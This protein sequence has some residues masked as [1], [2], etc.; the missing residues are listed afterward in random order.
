MNMR[1]AFAC[2]STVM[3]RA[4][5]LVLGSVGAVERTD[6]VCSDR[7]VTTTHFAAISCVDVHLQE[8]LTREVMN[9]ISEEGR[10]SCLAWAD[11]ASHG[12]LRRHDSYVVW[13]CLFITVLLAIDTVIIAA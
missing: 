9:G 7:H 2:A 12:V 1:I 11:H 5:S 4:C 13:H 6:R 3:A 10:P 8:L